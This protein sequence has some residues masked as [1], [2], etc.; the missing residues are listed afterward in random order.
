MCAN[1]KTWKEVVCANSCNEV[2][3]MI[4]MNKPLD[5]LLK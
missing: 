2:H 5:F 4:S 3:E 1:K